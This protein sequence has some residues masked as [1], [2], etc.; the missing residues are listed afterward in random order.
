MRLALW[1]AWETFSTYGLLRV[2]EL[3]HLSRAGRSS[4]G[5][6]DIERPAHL[7]IITGLRLTNRSTMSD[8]HTVPCKG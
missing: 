2:S 4:L 6:Q 8:E 3:R 1:L 5:Q 7:H